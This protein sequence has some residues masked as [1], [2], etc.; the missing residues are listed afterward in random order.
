MPVADGDSFPTNIPTWDELW[1]A[2]GSVNSSPPPA[3]DETDSTGSTALVLV[4][5]PANLST[6]LVTSAPVVSPP[7]RRSG[8]AP[9][10]AEVASSS[11]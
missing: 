3:A 4:P 10:R 9:D 6:A 1:T 8:R 11:C 5:Q 2:L 7:Q